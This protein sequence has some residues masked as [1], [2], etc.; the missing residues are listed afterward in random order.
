VIMPNMSG[1]TL[2]EQVIDRY[3][4]VGVVF[5]SGYTAEALNVERVTTRG[6]MFVAKPVTSRQLILA[7]QQAVAIRAAAL[8]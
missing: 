7:V 1:I 4:S 8:S 5:L 2:A 6:A 3:P